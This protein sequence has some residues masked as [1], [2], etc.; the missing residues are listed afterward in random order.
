MFSAYISFWVPHILADTNHLFYFGVYEVLL[1][2][3]QLGHT[4]RCTES[5]T[6]PH[7]WPST[8]TTSPPPRPLHPTYDPAPTPPPSPRPLQS[9]SLL[10]LALP[11][12]ICSAQVCRE[13]V[14]SCIPFFS[15]QGQHLDVLWHLP[16]S[17]PRALKTTSNQFTE[18]I[19]NSGCG[20]VAIPEFTQPSLHMDI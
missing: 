12:R 11:S 19:L 17:H 5:S 7:L 13:H 10:F 8:H 9:P 14:F 16:C 2:F 6:A 4:K 18:V 3:Q 15:R 20:C 1:W